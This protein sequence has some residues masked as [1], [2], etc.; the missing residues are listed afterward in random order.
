MTDKPKLPP[1]DVYA[2]VS[3]GIEGPLIGGFRKGIKHMDTDLTCEQMERICEMQHN[4]LMMWFAD[5]FLF[6]EED[7][8]APEV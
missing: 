5:T 8:N 3:D 1:V 6:N 4:Y 7:E 2:L